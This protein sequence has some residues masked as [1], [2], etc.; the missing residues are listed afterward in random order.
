MNPG[1]S[2][3]R[4]LKLSV[5]DTGIGIPAEKLSRIF[6]AFAQE[7]SSTTRRFGGTGLGLTISRRLV[8]AM[9]GEIGVSSTAG[10][11][12]CFHF[13]LPL[14]T[15]DG[16]AGTPEASAELAGRRAL[17]VDDHPANRLILERALQQAGLSSLGADGPTGAIDALR[18]AAA[19]HPVD[20][21]LLDAGMPGEDGFNLARR[22]LQ[23]HDI[24]RPALILLSPVGMKGDANRCREIGIDTFLTRPITQ[25]ELHQTLRRLLAHRLP[26]SQ[27]PAEAPRVVTGDAPVEDRQ[28]LR[29]LLAEDQS[30][31]Q[32]LVVGLLAR[33]GFDYARAIFEADREILSLIGSQLCAQLP[34]DFARLRAAITALDADASLRHT[35][36]LRG[37]VATMGAE[38]LARLLDA[39]EQKARYAD[40]GLLDPLLDE[41]EVELIAFR[42]ALAEACA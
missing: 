42:K 17:V 12:S 20:V 29:V 16:D 23:Q 32:K 28:G 11:G 33:Q 1:S 30:V 40:L 39:I 37:L 8:E 13:T 21:V 5:S 15:I 22:I 31:N 27:A 6:D 26:V 34:D 36:A 14:E 9:G 18:E 10:A 38:P 41:L 7:D 19:S 2:G 24:P 35:H 3:R 25:D 4:T